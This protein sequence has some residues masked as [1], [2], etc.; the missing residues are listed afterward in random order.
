MYGHCLAGIAAN[1]QLDVAE[2]E[3]CFREALQV[4]KRSGD[5][6]S[7]AARLACALLGEL[8]YERGEVD[9]ADRLLDESYQL[10]A[11]GGVVE[12]MIARYVIGARIKAVRGDRDC[13][14]RV[15]W[16]TARDVAATRGLPRLRAH[17]DNERMRLELPVAPSGVAHEQPR[18]P[19]AGSVRSPPSSAMRPKFAGCSPIN[20]AWPANAPR[21]GCNGCNIR[22]ARARCCRPTGCSWL[23]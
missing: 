4:A 9:E 12:F 14:R 10:G 11:E 1:E 19:T 5:T 23:P 22:A 3:R 21:P 7:H 17:V 15:A 13:R 18:S 2:A 16:T 20:P 8:L 6:H